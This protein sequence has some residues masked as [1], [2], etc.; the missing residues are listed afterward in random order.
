M[1]DLPWKRKLH[2]NCW[3]S[4]QSS[5]ME[6]SCKDVLGPIM[7]NDYPQMGIMEGNTLIELLEGAAY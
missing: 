3:K 2:E 5:G 4:H 1:K 7:A 6:G